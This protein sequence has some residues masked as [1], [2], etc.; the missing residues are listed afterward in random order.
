MRR[1]PCHPSGPG[2]CSWE[3]DPL[4]CLLSGS[5]I[6]NLGRQP[7]ERTVR[8]SRSC[9]WQ[10]LGE[11]LEVA[12]F[13][14][15]ELNFKLP[16]PLLNGRNG[17]CPG[18]KQGK[19][20]GSYVKAS[21]TQLA[22]I[23]RLELS[24]SKASHPSRRGECCNDNAECESAR[25]LILLWVKSGPPVLSH[26]HWKPLPGICNWVVCGTMYMVTQVYKEAR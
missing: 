22:Y 3:L 20:K 2:Y 21:S 24:V 16:Q 18:V 17:L 4:R 19:R 5:A 12:S 7:A 26:K 8:L 15:G 1:K 10:Q 11:K 6:A 23:G 25:S 9:E 14:A 13:V